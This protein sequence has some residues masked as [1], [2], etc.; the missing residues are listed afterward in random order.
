MSSIGMVV[1]SDSSGIINLAAWPGALGT[2]LPEFV[3]GLA[4]SDT[5]NG[6]GTTSNLGMIGDAG[7]DTM[8]GCFGANDYITGPRTNPPR[9]RWT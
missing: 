4:G 3:Y 5:I 2:A 9:L 1:A 7:T 6:G 8:T